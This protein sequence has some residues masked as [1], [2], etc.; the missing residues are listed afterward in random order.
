M[1]KEPTDIGSRSEVTVEAWWFRAVEIS[2]P[3]LGAQT[4][5]VTGLVGGSSAIVT[6]QGAVCGT[7]RGNI[8]G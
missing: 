4:P 3:L 6:G 5:A 1:A 2:T 8:H 7:C